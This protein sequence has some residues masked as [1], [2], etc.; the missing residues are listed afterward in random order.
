MK[1]IIEKTGEIMGVSVGEIMGRRRT[2]Q[3]ALA[4]Q[5][6][7]YFINRSGAGVRDTGK[8]FNR[9]HSN[10]SYATNRIHELRYCDAEIR[11]IV[12]RIELHLPSQITIY[13]TNDY[14]I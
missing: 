5:I 3:V 9:H 8:V 4:R 7:M 6:A 10:V 12:Q 13:S 11:G 14:Q 1:Y 2:K